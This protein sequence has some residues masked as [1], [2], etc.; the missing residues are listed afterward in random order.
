[1]ATSPALPPSFETLASQAPQDEV[2]F[3]HGFS[4]QTARAKDSFDTVIAS[5]RV[6]AKAPPDDRLREAIQLSQGDQEG[7]IGSSQVLPCANALR[8]SQA[9]TFRN[10]FGLAARSAR[11]LI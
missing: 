9:M 5:Q 8:L 3:G 1:M 10:K 11:G 6:S 7:W 2:S 4:C